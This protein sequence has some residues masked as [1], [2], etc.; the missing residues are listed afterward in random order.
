MKLANKIIAVTGGGSGIGRQV[1][2]A[3]L[4]RGARVA[5]IDLRPEGLEETSTLADAGERL[6][7]HT[8]DV[9][10]RE[11]V[12]AL[13]EA[14]IAAHGAVDGVIHCAGIIQPFVRLNDLDF[15]RIDK[16]LQ[17]NLYGTI[18]VDKAFLPYLLQRPEAHLTNVSSMGGFLPVPGQA[19]YGA[20]K[21][22]VKLLTE[23]LYA[24]LMGT[25]VRVSVV[26]PGAVDTNIT[27][28]SGVDTPHAHPKP[29]EEEHDEPS[30]QALPADKAARIILDGM[31]H[32]KLHILVGNDARM[33]WIGSRA[34][35]KQAI[36][37]IQR[38][39]KDLLG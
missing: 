6:S 2:L 9:V 21:A 37:M 7:L 31:E 35:P 28:N 5:A 26:M 4:Q 33:L 1:A 23:A 20:S 17:V 24:E 22:A 39:M 27:A 10:D 8:A 38:Q 14:V 11:A 32:D 12:M 25:N 15:D 34:A 29:G 13:P 18:H 36:H 30:Y 19:L 16:V 3:L